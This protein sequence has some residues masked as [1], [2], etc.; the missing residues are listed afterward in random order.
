MISRCPRQAK[1]PN[2]F[3]TLTITL[4]ELG[5][6]LW[7]LIETGIIAAGSVNTNRLANFN[8]KAGAA[9]N[10]WGIPRSDTKTGDAANDKTPFAFA[11]DSEDS[12]MESCWSFFLENYY[13]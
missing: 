4:S 10:V 1:R 3:E 9:M 8:C 11:S 13:D 6:I 7:C 5:P 2:E 12:G